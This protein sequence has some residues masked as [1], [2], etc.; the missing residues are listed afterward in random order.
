MK[1]FLVLAEVEME[2]AQYIDLEKK[3]IEQTEFITS[4][5]AD[6]GRNRGLKIK[7]R[8]MENEYHLLDD[9]CRSADAIAK[10]TGLEVIVDPSWIELSFG[11]WDGLA[12]EQV[13]SESP[14]EYQAWLNSSSYQPGGGESYDEAGIRIDDALDRLVEQFPGKR[15]V[16][17][18]HNGAIK[19]AINLALDG[20]SDGVFHMDASPCSIS[21]ISIWP[22]DG[23][24]AMRSF[25]ECG[26]HR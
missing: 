10:A 18:T 6:H 2:D 14:D 22:S 16:V 1:R 11:S 26:H 24:R 19:S 21:T 20:P 7:M 5:L 12:I 9:V 3:T 4:V 23:L 8:C 17:V 15:V 25:N 13:R